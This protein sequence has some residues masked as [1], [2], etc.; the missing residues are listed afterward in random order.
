MGKIVQYSSNEALVA[1]WVSK[2]W[3]NEFESAISIAGQNRN[4]SLSFN[5]E[6]LI[7]YREPLVSLLR[8]NYSE[9]PIWVLNKQKFSVT[10]SKHLR[11]VKRVLADMNGKIIYANYSSAFI[12]VYEAR[13]VQMDKG[14]N[15]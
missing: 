13:L 12:K 1:D 5:G 15:R 10:S 7:T 9:Q 2:C 8:V 11:L 3:M 6:V 14:L 4:G